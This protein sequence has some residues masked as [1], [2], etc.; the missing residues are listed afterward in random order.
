MARTGSTAKE[1]EMLRAR[2]RL[3]DNSTLGLFRRLSR[4]PLP[5]APQRLVVIIGCA[6]S[7]TSVLKRVLGRQH[8]VVA[9]PGEANDWWHPND[10]PWVDKL[11]TLPPLWVDPR[12]FTD[13]S[14][15]SWPKNHASRLKRMLRLYQLA[16]G[17]PTLVVK[18]SMINYMLPS[19]AELFPDARFIH[20][21]RDPRAVAVS[22][23]H[24]EYKKMLSA[25][26]IF[27]QRGLWLEF[28]EIVIRMAEFWAETI[29][30]IYGA[31]E[32]LGLE[33]REAYFEC[34]YEDFCSRP[35]T[36]IRDI[37][38]FLGHEGD[39]ADLGETVTNMNYKFRDG[40]APE[41]LSRLE[42]V[43]SDMRIPNVDGCYKKKRPSYYELSLVDLD[44]TL[45][46]PRNNPVG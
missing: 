16:H 31:V 15:A 2:Q 38:V 9:F 18:S 5:L 10:Y 23:A 22:Y 34:R 46:T 20:I 36:I 25:E 17:Q 3:S 39:V 21:V 44:C 7:G 12:S 40:L 30:E 37:L 19:L 24:K 1:Q 42:S 27:Q 28:D 26:S 33:Q 32:R 35:A 11:S 6:R 43:V 29:K 14:L 13:G 8:G 45:S 41:M 4:I